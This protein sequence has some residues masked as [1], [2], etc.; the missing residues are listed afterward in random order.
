MIQIRV[1]V[2]SGGQ[3][4]SARGWGWGRG[5]GRTDTITLQG[6]AITCPFH[7][8][9]RKGRLPYPRLFSEELKGSR[10]RVP[11]VAQWVKNL[12]NIHEDVGSISGLTQWI[13]DLPCRSQMWLG[14]QVA[15]AWDGVGPSCSSDSTPRPGNS[16]CCRW[17]LKKK[18]KKM[19]RFS[20]TQA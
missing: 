2:Y 4:G 8:Y 10:F 16:I 14:S 7:R 20:L 11:A 12:T 17:S 3:G 5:R 13:K 1:L 9:S 19:S 6:T 18:K 15:M